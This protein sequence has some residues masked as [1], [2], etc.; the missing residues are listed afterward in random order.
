MYATPKLKAFLGTLRAVNGESQNVMGHK[1]GLSQ[2]E[3]ANLENGRARI[4]PDFLTDIITAY[5]L[6][7][8]QQAELQEVIE[9]APNKILRVGVTTPLEG[10]LIKDIR[11]AIA[12]NT[13]APET[14]KNMMRLMAGGQKPK[15]SI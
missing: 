11:T 12:G 15:E 14:I 10:E 5:E 13:L 7:D 3:L 1:L 6:N 9:A 8:E 4:K 2:P